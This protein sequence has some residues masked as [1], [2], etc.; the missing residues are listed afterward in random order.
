MAYNIVQF[1]SLNINL[2]KKIIKNIFK[3]KELAPVQS[4]YILYSTHTIHYTFYNHFSPLFHKP[5]LT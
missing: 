1:G 4:T 3:N 2:K 5:P